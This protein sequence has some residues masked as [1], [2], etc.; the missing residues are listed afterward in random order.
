M[1]TYT[2]F[3]FATAMRLNAFSDGVARAHALDASRS[4]TVNLTGLTAQEQQLA[5]AALGEWRAIS[6]IQ[7]RETSGAADITYRHDG[8]SATTTTS[9]RGGEILSATVNIASS[10][11]APGDGVGSYAFRT[12][13]HETGHALGI[14][15]PQ[16]YT[17]ASDFSRSAI[18]ND[19]WQISL[20][21]Y[22]SQIENTV[23]EASHAY[24]LTPMLADYLAIRQAH[25]AVPVRAGNTVYGVG[26]TAGGT[27][28]QIAGTAARVTFLI[29]DTGGIDHIS[30]AGD[31]RSMRLDLRPGGISDVRGQIGNMQIA[32]DT[33]IE[34]ATGGRGND[35]ITG[36]AAANVL[37]GGGG[38]DTLVGAAGNDT[39]ITDGNDV[40]SESGGGGHDRVIA[41]ANHVLGPGFEDLVLAGAAVA[42]TGNM[43]ANRITGNAGANRLN[44]GGG[45]D[46][47]AGGAGNDTYFV[48]P[49]DMVVEPP[50]G[51][52]DIVMSAYS[53]VLAANVEQLVLT[54]TA[55]VNGTGNSMANRIQGNASANVL[56]GGAGAD[57]L[58]GGA[59]SDTYVVTPGDVVIEAP[60]GGIDIV[61][62]AAS[63]TLAANV[64]HGVLTG[65]A[66]AGLAG[67]G[68]DNRLTGNAAANTLSGHGGNDVLIGGGGA[69]RLHGGIGND[70]YIADVLDVI[71]ELAGQGY[72][73]VQTAGGGRL[74]AEVERMILT[75]NAAVGATGNA[76]HNL[77]IGNAAGNRL[78]G[79]AG[80]DSLRGGGGA[81]RFVFAAGTDVVLDF[82]NDIDTLVF[83]K[84]LG[85]STIDQAMTFARQVG[86]DVLFD[87]G[88]S[89]LRVLGT[90]LSDLRDDI[91]FL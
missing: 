57:T 58:V 80:N 15:H 53:H 36:N 29:A 62:S 25:G 30:F 35:R 77:L 40:L 78:D 22:F 55:A 85:A 82:Q 63:V 65:T 67:N 33:M 39:Y 13:M 56:N 24:N 19:S 43:Q 8:A 16:D 26:S 91:E 27:L 73:T 79:G 14:G 84:G 72:D 59:G 38:A 90:R 50:V 81:D 11:V 49:G 51:G 18:A 74:P 68:Q 12:Y 4:I 32:T 17:K 54:G 7:F 20:M 61:H 76:G 64:E 31:S 47:L 1:E 71:V 83:W 46:T 3:R 41:Y 69:D 37:N 88:A 45:V 34:N 60:G 10:R 9:Y 86:G 5:R 6:G 2:P 52:L 89:A 87:F 48:T 75:G 44:G 66:A 21:S 70:T 23:I 42:G 28:D